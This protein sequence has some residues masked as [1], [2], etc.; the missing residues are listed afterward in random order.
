MDL[1]PSSV[2]PVDQRYDPRVR[3]IGKIILALGVVGVI[4][5]LS[6]DSVSNIVMTAGLPVLILLGL[7]AGTGLAGQGFL[8]LLND[9]AIGG[10]IQDYV[11]EKNQEMKNDWVG[12][13]MQQ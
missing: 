13:Q 8:D 2:L 1:K 3:A 9:K 11:K 6:P 12:R 4:L 5:W 10:K 7:I